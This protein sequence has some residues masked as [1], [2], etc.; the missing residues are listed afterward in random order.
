MR[1]KRTE[2]YKN[3]DNGQN[4]NNNKNKYN[5]THGFIKTVDIKLTCKLSNLNHKTKIKN[6]N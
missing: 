2:I 1:K 6:T 4:V 3:K 5:E